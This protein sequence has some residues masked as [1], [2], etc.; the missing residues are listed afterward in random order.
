MLRAMFS[1]RMEVLTDSEGKKNSEFVYWN[2][3]RQKGTV[4]MF[5]C[6]LLFG[7]F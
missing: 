1:G 4:A 5:Y 7:Y 2:T 6:E 3:V